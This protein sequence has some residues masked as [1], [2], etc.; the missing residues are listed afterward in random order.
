MDHAGARKA[1]ELDESEDYTGPLRSLVPPSIPPLHVE[2]NLDAVTSNARDVQALVG[3]ACG[4]L[5][6][7]KADAYGH[8]LLPVARALQR[9]G[10]IAG[11]VVSSVR[12]GLTLRKEGITVPIVALVARYGDRH[13]ELLGAGVTPVL[14]SRADLEAFANAAR[15][16]GCRVAA[17]VEID[18]GMSRSG[19][20]EEDIGAFTSALADRP[21]I[22][23]VGLCT[24]L[25]SAD[26][27]RPATVLRQLDIFERACSRF[28]AAGHRPTLIHAANTAATF[29]LPR[30]HFTHVRVG[31]ALFGG[32][33][34]SGADLRPAM[35]VTT[36]V[37][38]LRSLSPGESV[39]Y[40]EKWRAARPSRIATLPIGYLHGYPRR[41][42]DRAEVLV[43]GQRCKVVGS[44]CM[45]MTMVDV[46]DVDGVAVDDAVV[47]IGR[48]GGA[49]IGVRELAR[50]MDGIVEEVLCAVP[51]AAARTYARRSP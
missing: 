12:D 2:V 33:E 39:G 9:D 36:R 49:Q 14:S 43:R 28:R 45:E 13:G 10:V 41:L 32:D 7:L 38:Q 20:R 18:T 1:L 44:I 21:A 30:A 34:P 19:I 8:G 27:E 6:M 3:P 50:A 37:A 23:V 29:R 48:D 17:H 31:I 40:G 35:R 22:E 47:L 46:T 25:A 11:I 4:V 5:A 15:V 51:K 16:R 42:L 26:E 24:Q